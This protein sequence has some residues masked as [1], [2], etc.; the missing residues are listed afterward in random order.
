MVSFKQK[1][2]S[3]LKGALKNK[4][5]LRLSVLRMLTAV[6]GNRSIEKRTKLSKKG[7]V[8]DLG[9]ESELTDD[10]IMDTIRSEVKKRKEAAEGFEK[11]GRTDS[12][13]KERKELEILREYLPAEMSDEELKKIVEE[14]IKS[15]G[16]SSVKDFGKVMG[17]VMGKVK[18]QA[19]GDRV[20]MMVKQKLEIQ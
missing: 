14:E 20:N 18:N 13:E 1:I 3:D 16:A 9:K 15:T 19:S 12:A 5:E 17:F 6:I 10:E 8:R 4:E 2:G 11:G 7:N